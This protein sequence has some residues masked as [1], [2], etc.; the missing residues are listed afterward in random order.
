MYIE[1][2]D[3]KLWYDSHK[4]QNHKTSLT[5]VGD[6]PM[7]DNCLTLVLGAT[8]SGKSYIL[9]D[10]F[11]RVDYDVIFFISPTGSFDQTRAERPMKA[12]YIF[13]YQ[14]PEEGVQKVYEYL[15]RRLMLKDAEEYIKTLLKNKK[16]RSAIVSD[17]DIEVAFEK[18][19]EITKNFPT[20][21]FR[22][23][24]KITT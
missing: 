12:K 21:V 23:E 24:Y 20:D 16:N 3:F 11:D 19:M 1:I 6:Y 7:A 9:K 8:G 2:E 15:M 22:M 4:Y 17:Y 13:E 5:P 18:V 14:E 10:I